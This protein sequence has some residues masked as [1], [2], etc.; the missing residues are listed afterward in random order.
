MSTNICWKLNCV[1]LPE[2]DEDFGLPKTTETG[3]NTGSNE[4]LGSKKD[5]YFYRNVEAIKI[6]CT[7]N[8]QIQYLI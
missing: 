6:V 2:V 8:I 7:S 5:L 3:M 1:L 4:P